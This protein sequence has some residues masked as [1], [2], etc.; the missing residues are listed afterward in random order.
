MLFLLINVFQ[1]GFQIHRGKTNYAISPLPADRPLAKQFIHVMR[2]RPLDFPNRF[3]GA[4]CRFDLDR[5]VDMRGHSA[6]ALKIDAFQFTA[7]GLN[8]FMD[9]FFDFRPD[10]RFIAPAMPIDVKKPFMEDMAGFRH[11]D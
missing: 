7:I 11:A 10:E 3:G 2:T 6:D 5:H 1:H 8:I 9:F 4:N